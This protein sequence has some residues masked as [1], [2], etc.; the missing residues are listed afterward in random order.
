MALTL[1]SWV[2]LIKL[3]I[4]STPLL[5]YNNSSNNS[6]Q[7]RG[8]LSALGELMFAKLIEVVPGKQKVLAHAEHNIN[9]WWV[10]KWMT[11][12]CQVVTRDSCCVARWP[13]WHQ[14]RGHEVPGSSQW[15]LCPSTNVWDPSPLQTEVRIILR[16]TRPVFLQ[17][18]DNTDLLPG[19]PCAQHRSTWLWD[20]TKRE[21]S[22]SGGEPS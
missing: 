5:H 14:L 3:Q 12:R 22:N 1:I 6:T 19:A 17:G 11:S 10:N 9:V 8:L 20:W 4:L 13:C 2:T 15:K 7:L 16:W 18:H 21:V